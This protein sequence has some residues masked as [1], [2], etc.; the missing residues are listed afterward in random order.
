[1]TSLRLEV[2]TLDGILHD[3][4]VSSIRA[5]D[6]DGWFGILPG[7][8]DVIA[9]LPPGLLLFEDRA[10]RGFLAVTRALL[11]LTGGTCRV[12]APEAGIAREIDEAAR[13]LADLRASRRERSR[14]HHEVMAGLEREALR[15]MASSFSEVP[16]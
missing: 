4:P 10:G 12:L 14:R 11:S 8:Q 3:G 5:E 16:G 13:I 1:M 7:R 15:R 9:T 6:R 2:R